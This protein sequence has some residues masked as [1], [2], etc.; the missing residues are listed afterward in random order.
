[1]GN[2][3]YAG[4]RAFSNA[5]VDSVEDLLSTDGSEAWQVVHGSEY[6]GL[7]FLVGTADLTNFDIYYKFHPDGDAA[8]AA[9]ADTDFTT[10]VHPVIKASGDLNVAAAGSTVHWAQLDIRGVYAIRLR[11]AGTSSAVSGHM[12]W[13]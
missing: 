3:A 8:L 1:M 13:N 5:D 2:P 4:F 6:L 12:S 11:A 7:S 9:N 10:P